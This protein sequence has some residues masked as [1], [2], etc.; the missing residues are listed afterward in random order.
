MLFHELIASTNNLV[1]KLTYV[2]MI[3]NERDLHERI[4]HIVLDITS[5]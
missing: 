1:K 4:K 5:S 3:L 2:T